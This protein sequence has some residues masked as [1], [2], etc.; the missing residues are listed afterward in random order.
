[1]TR[2]SSGVYAVC[3]LQR[4]LDGD[5][6]VRGQSLL[7]AGEIISLV[8]SLVQLS[9]CSS[10]LLELIPHQHPARPAQAVGA[11]RGRQPELRSHVGD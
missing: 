11:T 1:M 7:V 2:L 8:Q 5:R 9:A 10:P 6:R 3:T 4:H